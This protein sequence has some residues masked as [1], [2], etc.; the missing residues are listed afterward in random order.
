[1]KIKKD[2]LRTLP[3]KEKLKHLDPLGIILI[4]GATSCLFLALQWGGSSLPWHS[5]RIIGL[6]I[7]F[8]LLL[9]T[10]CVLQWWLAERATIPL[11]ILNQRTV[12]YGALSLFFISLSSNIKLYYLPFYFQAVC[13]A[14]A[15]RS[16]VEFLALAVPQVVATV[17]AGGLATKTG[18]YVL[19]S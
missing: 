10:F 18:H 13:G 12:L 19:L 3:A 15:L 7:G 4:L 8:V 2:P 11:R 16:G 5:S 1:M 14:S 9:L 6:L 17:V